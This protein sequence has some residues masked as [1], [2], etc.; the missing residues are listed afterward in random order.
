MLRK[1][2]LPLFVLFCVGSGGFVSAQE[3]NPPAITAN[4]QIYN[5]FSPEQEM[6][7]GDLNHQQM[8]GD[9]RFIQDEKLL[10]YVRE[11]GARLVRHLP[12]TGLKFQFFIIDIPTANAFN[13][14]GGYV[15]LSRKLI[16]FT[17]TEDELAGVMA[18]E[19]GHATVHHGASDMSQLFK[20]ILNVTQLGD[21]KDITEK[22]NLLLE[23]E[24][25]KSV[26][27][28]EDHESAQQLE[29][30]RIGLFAMVAAGYDPNAFTD[31][32]SRLVEEKAKSGN[33]F[34]N[35]FGNSSPTQK[36]L[37][38]MVKAVELLPTACREKRGDNASQAY[39][40]WQADVV[41]FRESRI[42]EELPGML[43]KKE[44]SPQ[45][46]SDI[47][48]FAISDDGTYFLTQDDFAITVIKRDPL[49]ILF[50]IPTTDARPATFTPD[51]LN[52]VFV[53]EGLRFEKWS[54]ADAKA[55]EIREL[56]VRRDCWEHK[57]SPDG[58]YLA[59]VDYSL[60]LNLLETQSGKKVWEKKQFYSLNFFE[61]LG[62][63][64]ALSK[65]DEDSEYNRF[66]HLE[67]SPDSHYL[68]VSRSSKFRFRFTIDMMTADQT[69]DTML[70]LD[71]STLK[72]VTTG[73]DLK[74]ATRRPFIFVSPD[75]ILAMMPANVQDG[76]IFSFPQGKRLAKFPLFATELERTG[77]PNYVVLKPLSNA[78]MGFFDLTKGT[79]VSGMNKADAT[80]WNDLMFFELA[81]GSVSVSK[82][83]Y[84][85]EDK[86]LH[87]TRVG[88]IDIPVGSMNRL[89][90]ASISDDLHWLAASSKSRGAIWDLS[91]GERKIHVRGFRGAI[92]AADGAAIG[93]FPRL[94]PVKHSLVWMSAPTDQVSTLRE[95]PEQ[96]SRQYGRFVMF[97]QS[98]KAPKIDKQ[99]GKE[100]EK[101]PAG[102]AGDDNDDD[103]SLTHEVKFELR[104]VVN[105]KAIWSREFKKEAPRFFFDDYS[106]RLIFYWDLGSE[107]GKTRLKEDPTLQERSHQMGNKDDDYLVEVYDAFANKSVGVLLLETG[108]GSFYIES[109]FSEGDWLVLRDNNNRV[110]IYSIKSGELRHRFF[111]AHAAVNPGGNQ[112][113]VENYPGELT[114]YDLTTGNTQARLRF[115]TA[116]AFVRFSLDG[117]KLFVLTA[118]QVAHAFDVARLTTPNR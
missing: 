81:S 1:I 34:T 63:V 61:Y 102:I 15:F 12:N 43:W 97:R 72:P 69:E 6:I 62:W 50:Q 5:I 84:K 48:H 21:R 90:A 60:G 117:K 22:F 20:K 27:Q 114:V 70:A 18:H 35:I 42:A 31:F 19:L 55:V 91:S 4:A 52:V 7:L 110:L 112:V 57:L 73:G 13:T 8:A 58:K 30:D 54:I 101:P 115:K 92:V 3:C 59:C 17:K 113:I 82:V 118:G 9:L 28:S 67:F 51:G 78:P 23:R 46:K 109:G 32:F 99:K 53:T 96:G 29:A 74:K 87:S 33:W 45:L 11:I 25:T 94:E 93:D 77:N 80:L 26:S 106:G 38:E 2:I 108:Q 68:L 24:R 49:K 89:Y 105:D 65:L 14:P 103:E 79:I 71:L 76:G 98:L 75:K 10:A 47:S 116:T 40:N 85:E 36:R 64:T 56:V 107:A 88:T 111:G 100:G 37:R 66:F 83:E 16:A 39:L 104:D 44:L 41:S 86:V 95:I